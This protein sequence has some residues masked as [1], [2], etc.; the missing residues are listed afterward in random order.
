MFY[1]AN[2]VSNTCSPRVVV[3]ARRKLRGLNSIN[4]IAKVEIFSRAAEASLLMA[5]ESMPEGA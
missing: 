5:A 2:I 3:V 4:S 1:L